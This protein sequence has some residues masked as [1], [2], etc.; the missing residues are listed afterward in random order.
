LGGLVT[1]DIQVNKSGWNERDGS[2]FTL[3][4]VAQFAEDTYRVR[5]D[6]LLRRRRSPEELAT[7]Q[8]TRS[9]EPE[10]QIADLDTYRSLAKRV[11]AKLPHPGEY[12]DLNT[13]LES[14][15]PWMR[16]WDL[17][18]VSRWFEEFIVPRLPRLLDALAMGKPQPALTP[19]LEVGSL[20]ITSEGD[21]MLLR[22]AARH[23][24][25]VRVALE[26]AWRTVT[27]LGPTHT[28]VLEQGGGVR[29][30]LRTPDLGVREVRWVLGRS[31][32]VVLVEM[33]NAPPVGKA[34]AVEDRAGAA[35]FDTG[36]VLQVQADAIAAV[37]RA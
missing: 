30:P 2:S 27:L 20:S 4:F 23:A 14:I 28:L 12:A 6:D 10:F 3:N 35:R 22:L 26:K 5:Y 17:V 13:S 32:R 21:R 19:E 24:P 29:G 34:C 8:R 31:T 18:D 11:M 15:E 1:F 7:L 25:L 16:Y 36:V 37:R 9:A 33:L